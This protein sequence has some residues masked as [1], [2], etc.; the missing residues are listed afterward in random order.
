M[1]ALAK[2][3]N[4]SQRQVHVWFL[5]RKHRNKSTH[6]EMD[7]NVWKRYYEALRKQ[8]IKLRNELGEI[9]SLKQAAKIQ[10]LMLCPSCKTVFSHHFTTSAANKY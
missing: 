5:N 9:K 7:G 3:L 2:E 4:I 8:N 1:E 6:N 10:S